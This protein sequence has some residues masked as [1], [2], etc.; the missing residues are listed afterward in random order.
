M[1]KK[2]CE[3]LIRTAKEGTKADK[4]TLAART[5]IPIGCSCRVLGILSQD[6][7]ND[8][9]KQVLNNIYFLNGC[10]GKTPLNADFENWLGFGAKKATIYCSNNCNPDRIIGEM[11]TQN[12]DIVSVKDFNNIEQQELQHKGFIFSPEKLLWELKLP[13]SADRYLGSIKKGGFMRR[14]DRW[15]KNRGI[16]FVIDEKLR[17]EKLLQKWYNL[18]KKSMETKQR[19][20]EHITWN[21]LQNKKHLTAI[22]AVENNDVLG[23]ILMAENKYSPITGH[24]SSAGY[25]TFSRKY[26]GISDVLYLRMVERSIEKGVDVLTLGMDTNFYGY[27]LSPGLYRYKRRTGFIPRPLKI[28]KYHLLK[29]LNPEHFDNPYMFIETNP[30]HNLAV[31]NVFIRNGEDIDLEGFEGKDGMKV[32]HVKG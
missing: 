26:P 21:D 1:N 11:E 19:G 17:D 12:V 31:N 14:R 13:K 2:T 32:H 9:K 6:R 23:G 8:V 25:G 10:K 24:Y 28:K 7:D 15:L 3:T 20:K 22:Y 27:H 16:K 18:Y 4:I 5:D 29:V 30:M